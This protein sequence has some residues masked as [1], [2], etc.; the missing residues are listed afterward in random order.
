MGHGTAAREWVVLLEAADEKGR[1]PIDVASFSRLIESWVDV[2]PTT[3]FS[4]GRYAVQFSV[5]AASAPLALSSALWHWAKAVRGAGLP[6]WELV[7]AELLTPEELE[8]DIQLSERPA[9]GGVALFRAAAPHPLAAIEDELLRRALHDGLTGLMSREMFLDEIREAVANDVPGEAIH[10]VVVVDLDGFRPV[11]GSLDRAAGDEVLVE[12]ADRLTATIRRADSVASVGVDELAALVEVR[13]VDEL[14]RVAERIMERVG[15][16]LLGYGRP[17]V[18]TVSLGAAMASH[19]DHP[20]VVIEQ[21][22]HAMRTTKVTGGRD[23]PSGAGVEPDVAALAEAP[24]PA[25]RTPPRRG[26]RPGSAAE[27]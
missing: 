18:V 23:R 10:G 16:P 21:A 7:R 27:G 5:E 13:S 15:A 2:T 3:L 12:M 19:W 17:L 25:R 14:W 1:T 24:V 11:D 6:D 22:E 26:Q 8:R 4:P 9:V 20:D